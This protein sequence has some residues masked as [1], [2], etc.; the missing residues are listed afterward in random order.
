[1]SAVKLGAFIIVAVLLVSGCGVKGPLYLPAKEKPQ[2]SK[3]ETVEETPTNTP[4]TS[5]G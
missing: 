4:D 2:Q 3:P 5:K 1:M